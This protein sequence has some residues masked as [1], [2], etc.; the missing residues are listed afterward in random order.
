MEKKIDAETLSQ[1]ADALG[2]IR[3][4]KKILET[5]EKELTDYLKLHGKPK[6]TIHG[7]LFDVEIVPST[8]RVIDA[9]KTFKKLGKDKFLKI[10]SVTITAA[11][12]IMSEEDIDSVSTVEEGSISVRTKARAIARGISGSNIG[13]AE[14]IEL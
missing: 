12:Q 1:Y 9:I 2:D 13:G 8:K 7:K 3:A 14:Q 5:K 4:Q 10:C 6:V 11:A